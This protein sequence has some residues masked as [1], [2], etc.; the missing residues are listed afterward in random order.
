MLLGVSADTLE[1][2][3]FEIVVGQEVRDRQLLGR[4]L[5]F[6]RQQGDQAHRPLAA[7]PA[8]RL[9]C[10]FQKGPRR[11][12]GRRGVPSSSAGRGRSMGLRRGFPPGLAS[13]GWPAGLHPA[14]GLRA[15]SDL[16]AP[17]SC[18]SALGV[19]PDED[20]RAI[21]LAPQ[22]GSAGRVA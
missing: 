17:A 10:F 6:P 5:R 16:P 15:G 19:A 14:P 7:R 13:S 3:P 20:P 11:P 9:R 4:Y 8:T 22:V 12:P 21:S 2:G 1:D 18:P